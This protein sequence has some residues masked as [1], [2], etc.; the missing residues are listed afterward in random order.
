MEV[1]G[2]V[3]AR[4]LYIEAVGSEADEKVGRG[5]HC[6]SI[7][8][9]GRHNDRD[10]SFCA[11]LPAGALLLDHDAVEGRGAVPPCRQCIKA[12]GVRAMKRLADTSAGRCAAAGLRRLGE[13]TGAVLPHRLYVEQAGSET[14]E[15]VGCVVYPVS[16]SSTLYTK[17]K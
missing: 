8:I 14:N 5:W 3:S 9:G 13:G 17:M 7:L 15:E 12:A 2:A 11:S 1:A 6:P 16:V 10:G 4:R